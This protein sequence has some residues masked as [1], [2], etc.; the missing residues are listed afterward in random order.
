MKH[1]TTLPLGLLLL[2]GAMPAGAQQSDHPAEVH[3]RNNCRLAAQVFETGHP[4][5]RYAW[6]QEYIMNCKDEGP[7]YFA[8]QW[9]TVQGDTSEL[10][11]ILMGST[12]IRDARVYASLRKTA[13]DRSR[14]DAVRVAALIGLT[15][16]VN[17]GISIDISELRP[18]EGEVERI[19]F[20]GGSAV[21]YVHVPGARP[22]GPV[23]DEVLPLLNRI[24]A[25]RSGEPRQVWYAAA[26]LARRLQL[27]AAARGN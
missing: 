6:A 21:D 13:T 12:R 10:R 2:V 1:T 5:P 25:D 14:P 17:P 27:D 23:A 19:R 20:Y 18:P 16:Y 26:V 8:A 22:I 15:E 24:A 11:R 9:A 3:H 4:H 7:A